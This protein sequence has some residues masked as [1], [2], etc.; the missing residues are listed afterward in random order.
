[1]QKAELD[2]RF[3]CVACVSSHFLIWNRRPEW[4][5]ACYLNKF[6]FYF[7][8]R[9]RVIF[10]YFFVRFSKLIEILDDL[11][12]VIYLASHFSRNSTISEG[13]YISAM[14]ERNTNESKIKLEQ[15]R[16]TETQTQSAN[17]INN[18][19]ECKSVTVH[20]RS[21]MKIENKTRAIGGWD[22]N[23]C[24]RQTTTTR[25]RKNKVR[26]PIKVAW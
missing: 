2:W 22:N 18:Y 17:R 13:L 3:I 6:F 10:F 20:T 8:V 11:F 14:A 26:E 9:S 21:Q 1:M 16:K 4:A 25:R 7:F 15:M 12:W 24:E 5:T 23:R 19:A